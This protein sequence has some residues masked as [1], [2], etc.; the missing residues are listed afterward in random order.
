MVV[1]VYLKGRAGYLTSIEASE[2]RDDTDGDGGRRTAP[3]QSRGEGYFVM[4]L[5][6]QH[7]ARCPG[8]SVE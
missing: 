3:S 8:L 1:V 7:G 4:P 2:L 5:V 6:A